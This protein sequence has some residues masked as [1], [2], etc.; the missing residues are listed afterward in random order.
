MN[1]FSNLFPGS[2]DPEKR[3]Q[4]EAFVRFLRTRALPFIN[5][6][7]LQSLDKIRELQQP[8]PLDVERLRVVARLDQEDATE[9]RALG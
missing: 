2:E 1:P 6:D 9:K 4:H 7:F 5:P 8:T 3:E